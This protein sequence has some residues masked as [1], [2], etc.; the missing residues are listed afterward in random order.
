MDSRITTGTTAGGNPYVD[1]QHW[2]TVDQ[3]AALS[4]AV[5]AD[6]FRRAYLNEWC[7]GPVD[8]QGHLVRCDVGE[9]GHDGPCM[10]TKRIVDEHLC[11]GHKACDLS[12]CFRAR[13]AASA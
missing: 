11:G 13:T 2:M 3:L 9:R 1:E 6:E 7:N 4:P 10:S 8:F 5:D 12:G